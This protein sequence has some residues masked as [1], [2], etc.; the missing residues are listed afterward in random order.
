MLTFNLKKKWFNKIKSGEKTH[1]YREVKPYWTKRL[2]NELLV[3]EDELNGYKAYCNHV[4]NFVRGYSN[5]ADDR[6]LAILVS[7]R[8]V[9][10][11]YTD[12]GIDKPVYVIE[13]EVLPLNKKRV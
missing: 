12:L 1:E 5:L 8:V 3:K 4:I 9:N 7:I 11:K 13:F 6:L 10:G 2:C